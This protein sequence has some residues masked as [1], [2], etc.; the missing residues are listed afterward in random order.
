MFSLKVFES[1][2]KVDTKRRNLIKLAVI[3]SGAFVLGKI[4][5]PSINL[6]SQEMVLDDGSKETMFNNFRVQENGEELGIYDRLG[7]EILVIEKD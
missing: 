6:F 3:G 1:L 7:N 2:N 5:G 4:L